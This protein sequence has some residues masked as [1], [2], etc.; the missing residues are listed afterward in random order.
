MQ[1]QH[2]NASLAYRA[3]P[4]EVMRG[5]GELIPPSVHRLLHQSM[6]CTMRCVAHAW[7]IQV[8]DSW[9][10]EAGLQAAPGQG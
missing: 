3:L 1:Q 9:S 10:T 6:R 2:A 5:V 4:A 8:L 7:K